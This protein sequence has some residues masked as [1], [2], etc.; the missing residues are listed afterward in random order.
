MIRARWPTRIGRR[1]QDVCQ[2]ARKRDGVGR[3]EHTASTADGCPGLRQI[4]A[5]AGV[6]MTPM[7]DWFHI[8]MR[9]QHL[10]Q[11]ASGLSCGNS[12]QTAAKDVIAAEV[13]CLHWRPWNDEAANARI[14][15]DRIHAVVHHIHFKAEPG[16]RKSMAPSQKL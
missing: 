8:G 14:S 7:L 4:L 9:L 13:E 5:D 3:T 1:D 6:A 11:V 15:I 2:S 10:K 16:T 12:S